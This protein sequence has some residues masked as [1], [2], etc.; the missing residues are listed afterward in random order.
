VSLAWVA[1]EGLLRVQVLQR[2]EAKGQKQ[3]AAEGKK[4]GEIEGM[5]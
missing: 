4:E 5:G 3:E 2:G 1:V